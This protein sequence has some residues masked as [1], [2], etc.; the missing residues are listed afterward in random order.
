MCRWQAIGDQYDLPVGSVLIAQ[1]A[2]S[3]SERV[4]DV[5]K[6]LMHHVFTDIFATHVDFELDPWIVDRNRLGH[7]VDDFAPLT[8]FPKGVH[9]D[10]ADKVAGEFAANQP[11][12]RQR[13]SFDVD[14]LPVV[15]HR[16]AHVHDDHGCGFWVVSRFV[17]F[18]VFGF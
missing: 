16:T 2:P 3:Q 8:D 14:V 9:F 12:H 7:H 17:N 13:H 18:D 1:K 11:V 5:C 6:M 15:A 10:K 4:L